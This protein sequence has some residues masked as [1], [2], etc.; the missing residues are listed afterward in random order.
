L[1]QSTIV[2]EISKKEEK[3]SRWGKE[4]IIKIVTN[5]NKRLGSCK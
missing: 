3:G 4:K 2:I 5:L 1:G